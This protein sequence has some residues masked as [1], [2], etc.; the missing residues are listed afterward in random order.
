VVPGKYHHPVVAAHRRP[1]DCLGHDFHKTLADSSASHDS[2]QAIKKYVQAN[3]NLG[4]VSDATF[5]N[6][7]NKALQKG[8]DSGVFDRPKGTSSP[9]IVPTHSSFSNRVNYTV[10]YSIARRSTIS[11]QIRYLTVASFD[12]C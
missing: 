5:T 6:Q 11:I 1:R 12:C 8:S 4:G 7:F 9:T 3:N 10:R 2:R